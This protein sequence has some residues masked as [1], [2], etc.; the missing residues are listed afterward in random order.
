M[1]KQEIGF[2]ELSEYTKTA[3]ISRGR[4]KFFHGDAQFLL[5]TE[6]V[7]FFRRSELG[8]LFCSYS[9]IA[10]SVQVSNSRDP[11]SGLLFPTKLFGVLSRAREL[12]T[13]EGEGGRSDMHCC[14]F[15]LRF[16]G[17]V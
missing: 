12:A 10:C 14:L 2:V 13:G 9:L 17:S 6:R 16:A 8:T 1:K 4:T 5:Y 3:D 7:H 11:S 15:S